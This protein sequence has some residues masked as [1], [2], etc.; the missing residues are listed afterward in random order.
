MSMPNPNSLDPAAREAIA[1][2]AKWWWLFL[3]SGSLG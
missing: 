3:V 2:V 1:G